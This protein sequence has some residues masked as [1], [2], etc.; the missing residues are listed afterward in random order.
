MINNARAES[1]ARSVSGR[2]G[3]AGTAP[4]GRDSKILPSTERGDFGS[5][6]GKRA[7]APLSDGEAGRYEEELDRQGPAHVSRGSV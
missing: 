3:A 2:G 4:A 1:D 7:S 6:D 5:D